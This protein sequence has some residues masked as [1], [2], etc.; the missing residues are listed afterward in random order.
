M[1]ESN[2]NSNTEV[3]VY[4]E[5]VVVP[6]DV[7]RVRVHP[8]VTIIPDKAFKDQNKKLEEIELSDGLL[9]IGEEAFYGCSLKQI[10]LPSTLRTLGHRAFYNCANIS[11]VHLPDYIQNFGNRYGCEAFSRC[12]NLANFRMSPPPRK[13][14]TIPNEIVCACLNLFSVEISESDVRFHN[15]TAFAW[16]NSLRNIAIPYDV[17][18]IGGFYS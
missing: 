11:T 5:G 16:C 14:S 9:E 8:S 6:E 7:V 3:F 4:T 2:N 15:S 18:N 10:T 12:Y 17:S 13:N 1:D